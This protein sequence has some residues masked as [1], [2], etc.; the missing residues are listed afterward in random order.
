MQREIEAPVL[1]HHSRSSASNFD[2]PQCGQQPSG[3]PCFHSDTPLRQPLQ[4]QS[5]TLLPWESSGERF[6]C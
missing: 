5:A 2:R 3:T 6:A 4:I 1:L